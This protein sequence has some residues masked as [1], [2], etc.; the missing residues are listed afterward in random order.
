MRRTLIAVAAVTGAIFPSSVLA[1]SGPALI[2]KLYGEL[3]VGLRQEG[4]AFTPMRTIDG[5]LSDTGEREVWIEIKGDAS[6]GL[7]G[8]CDENCVDLD[9]RAIDSAGL[10]VASDLGPDDQPLLDL[11]ASPP[12]LYRIQ[13]TMADCGAD[14][15]AYS[16]RLYR[17]E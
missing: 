7:A 5:E 13:T 9:L 11:G 2:D 14:R 16:L 15:C 4:I 8:M 3:E 1:Q 17:W 12:G 6:Y 10:A